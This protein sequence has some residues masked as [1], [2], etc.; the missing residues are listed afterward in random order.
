LCAWA[1]SDGQGGRLSDGVGLVVLDDGGGSRA[2]TMSLAL[3]RRLNCQTLTVGS[4]L[5]DSLSCRDPDRRNP[6]A[7]IRGSW[8][9]SGSWR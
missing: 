5:A 8:G 3:Q 9:P 7:I 1:V 6:G 2:F 4:I